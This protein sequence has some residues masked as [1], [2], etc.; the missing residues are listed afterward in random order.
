M[1]RHVVTDFVVV[2]EGIDARIKARDGRA[3]HGLPYRNVP[4]VF[5]PAHRWIELPGR[6]A[7]PFLL[8]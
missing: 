8:P 5:I 2:R 3:G 4:P 6:L 7:H 1:Q